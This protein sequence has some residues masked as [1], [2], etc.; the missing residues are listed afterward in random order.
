M[1]SVRTSYGNAA[2]A[3]NDKERR[4]PQLLGKVRKEQPD[5]PTFPQLPLRN[6]YENVKD[7]SNT[8]TAVR[9]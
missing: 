9:E 3:E 1:Q 7:Q 5:S 4:F 2:A 6:D 8:E